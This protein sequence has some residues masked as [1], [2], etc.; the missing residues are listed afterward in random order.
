MTPEISIE[1]IREAIA[2]YG[3]IRP[4]GRELGLAESTIRYRL[5]KDNADILAEEAA[6]D[7]EF[8]SYRAPKPIIFDPISTHNRYFIF[9][10]AQDGSEIHT[11]FWQCL[12]VYAD[13]LENCEIIVS[14]FTYS[15][16]LFEEHDKRAENVYFHPDIDPFVQHDRIRCGDEVEFCG[17]MNTLPTAVTPLS[18]FSTYTRGRWGIFPHPKVQLESIA[19][20]K[21][22]RA[23]QLMT[24]GA[25][26]LPNYIRKKA[27]IKAM[28]HH[29]IGAVLVEMRPDGSTYCRH[30]L[31]T[32]NV[33]GSFYDLDRKVTNKG[34]TEGHRVEAISYGDIH[35][36]KLDPKLAMATWAYDVESHTIDDMYAAA[37]GGELPLRDFLRPVYEFY[38]DLSDFSPRNHHNIKDHHFRFAAH[39]RGGQ[40]NNVAGALQGCADFLRAIHREDIM[41][42]VIESNHDQALLKWLKTADYRD[43][44]E[45]AIF[46]LFCQLWIYQMLQNGFSEPDVL[47]YVLREMGCPEDVVF[48][49]E[50]ES[51]VICGDIECGMHG[52]LGPNGARG[53]PL[54]ISRAGMKSN[55]GHTHSPAIRDGAYVGGVSATLDLGYNKGPSSWSQS[56][57]ITYPNG[58]RTIITFHNGRYYA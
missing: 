18:G 15:K 23:K 30:L 51:F 10:A 43:D 27:G 8:K 31:A 5:K 4:A 32:D 2:I 56:H 13:W 9:T 40:D 6:N 16:K 21:H 24:T 55:T 28:F 50:D 54:S 36:E 48:V 39:V 25:V 34:V 38:H 52:H 46:F 22:E 47:Q 53:S 35:H 17:E 42:I 29:Q 20:M 26:T 37:N 49:N 33:D 1:E 57:I 41:S 3:G 58:K 11:D 12:H 14:G 44:P 45:N 7:P 19:T